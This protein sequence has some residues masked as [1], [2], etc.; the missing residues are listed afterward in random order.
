MTDIAWR[1]AALAINLAFGKLTPRK[2]YVYLPQY[3]LP[4]PYPYYNPPNN[5]SIF[6]FKLPGTY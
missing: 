5:P 3:Y 6:F 4:Q 2:E 1:L